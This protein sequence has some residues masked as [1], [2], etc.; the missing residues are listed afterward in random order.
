VPLAGALES[1][2]PVRIFVQLGRG[3]GAR[4]WEQR[5]S[6]GA[7]PGI[8]ERLPYGYYHAADSSFRIDYSEDHAETW[9]SKVVR[10]GL[11]RLLGF[12]LVHAWRNRRMILGADAVWTHTEFEHLAA[13]ALLR[14][15]RFRPRPK[16]IAQS[17]WLFDRWRGLSTTKRWLY[18]TL[19][20]HA[21]VLTVQSPAN[22]MVLR[23]LLPQN[24]SELVLYGNDISGLRPATLRN[25]HNPARIVALGNDM[26]RDWNTLIAALDGWPGCEVRIGS[27]RL[28]LRRLAGKQV[29]IVPVRSAREAK[30]LYAWGEI[31]VVPLE[32]NL[33]ASG[34]TVISEAVVSGLPVVCTRT[35][36]L[37]AY[38]SEQEVRYVPPEDL[39]AVRCALKELAANDELRCVIA[40]KAQKRILAADLSSR[41]R[42]LRLRKLTEELLAGRSS[43]AAQ[44]SYPGG[45]P[46]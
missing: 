38:F 37:S 17:I 42:A 32:R 6:K 41:A 2:R 35:G 44:D 23:R 9:P 11:R 8:N 22:L 34:I 25:G 40:E 16:M 19:L 1:D 14:S 26:H 12:D 43:N 20:K 18:R 46:A 7:I 21:D 28:G 10:L 45:S 3:F 15:F 13:L 4:E 36:G 29:S 31:A 39:E 5:W 24:R 33:H 27:T 30:D